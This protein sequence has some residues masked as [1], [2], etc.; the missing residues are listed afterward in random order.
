MEE[1]FEESTPPDLKEIA[2][3]FK[4]HLLPVKSREIYYKQWNKFKAWCN[5]REVPDNYVSENVLLAYFSELSKQYKV[6]SLW[7]ILSALKAIALYQLNIDISNYERLKAVIKQQSSTY[8]AKKSMVFTRE[9]IDKFLTTAQG[10]EWTVLKL[11]LLFGL[12]GALRRSENSSLKFKDIKQYED[13]LLITVTYSKTDQAGNGRS[14]VVV[15]NPDPRLCALTLYS[16]YMKQIPKKV[17][18]DSKFWLQYRERW[19]KYTTQVRGKTF[20]SDLPKTIARFLN[21]ESPERYTGHAIRRTAATLLAD[22]GVDM[23]SLKRFGQWKSDSVCE[24]YIAESISNKKRLAELIANVEQENPPEDPE[25]QKNT[26]NP[27]IKESNT[28]EAKKKMFS[29]SWLITRN[30]P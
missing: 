17:S 11:A 4:E 24:G 10:E 23:I 28:K 12:S 20:F 15:K 25:I 1:D 13:H 5:E 9:Q 21:L 19:K 27:E 30:P 8:K 16:H 22:Q 3:D 18:Q 2:S 14:F 7:S 29:R 6:S 26:S